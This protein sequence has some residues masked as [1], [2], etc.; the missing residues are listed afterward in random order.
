MKLDEFITQ[1]LL[2][3]DNGITKARGTTSKA[4]QVGSN[5]DVSFDVAVTTTDTSSTEAGGEVKAGI[6]QV[7]GIG[8][9]GKVSKENIKEN[10][11]ISR[12][13]FSV[14]VPAR[15]VTEDEAQSRAVAEANRTR[16]ENLGI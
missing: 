3:I 4:Y 10:I 7:I 1:V 14:H 2:D 16:V 9:G 11:E 5:G 12:I 8:G 15:T 13:Q 6:V